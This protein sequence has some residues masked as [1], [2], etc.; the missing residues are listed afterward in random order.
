MATPNEHGLVTL[1]RRDAVPFSVFC[2]GFRPFFL[3][4][5]IWAAL[6]LAIWLSVLAGLWSFPGSWGALLWHAHEM[7]FGFVPAALAGFLLT[8]VPKWTKTPRVQ[9]GPLVA[10]TAL[11]LAGRVALLLAG[12]LPAAPVAV[13]DLL[14]LP[15]LAL[16]VASPIV[17]SRSRRNYGFPLLLGLLAVA[18][19]LVHLALMGAPAPNALVALRLGVYVELVLV[20]VV[21]GRI[22]P[23][24]TASAFERAGR[25]L[26]LRRSPSLDRLSLLMALA[27]LTVD[28]LWPGP[29]AGSLCLAAAALLA[30]RLAGW[31]GL[32]ARSDAL[33]LVLHLSVAMVVL[34]FGARALADFGVATPGTAPLHVFTTGG[35]G[36]TILAVMSRASLGHTG[37]GLSADG[38]LTAAYALVSLGALARGFLPYVG[39]PVGRY[40]VLAGGALWALGY[41]LFAARFAPIL[42]RPR[43]DGRPG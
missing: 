17:R 27:A 29:V 34:G 19:G 16:M 30:L 13:A 24:F 36:L 5:G 32:A 18:N 26:P 28:L 10:L 3:L 2:H 41:L 6:P 15:A 23:N 7:V 39:G 35:L 38:P 12:W 25:D 1:G 14:F 22:V 42:L 9:G 37:R 20:L 21:A 31:R 4:A 33:V 11:W 40:A 43:V 8:A